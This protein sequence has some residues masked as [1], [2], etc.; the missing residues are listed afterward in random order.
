[1]TISRRHL[2]GTLGVIGAGGFGVWSWSKRSPRARPDA[3]ACPSL[4]GQ[5]IRWIVP[6]A[7]GGGYDTESRLIER[8]LEPRL[9]VQIVVDNMP[10]AGGVTGAQTI[11]SA[12]PDGRTL[13][14]IGAPGLL[15]SRL[16]GGANALDPEAFTILGR[17]SRSW[18]VWAAGRHSSLRTLDDVLSAS[19]TRPLVFALSE[20]AGVNFVSAGVTAAILGAPITMVPG[21]EGSQAAALAAVRGDVDLVSFDFEA[22]RSLIE[23]GD[24]RPLL[25]VSDRPVDIHEALSDVAVL[26]GPQGWVA[27]HSGDR[28]A[29]AQHDQAMTSA[30]IEV[31]S[32]GRIVVA[33]PKMDPAVAGCLGHALHATL[34]SAE[35]RAAT[36]RSLDVATGDEARAD[37]IAAARDLSLLRPPLQQALAALRG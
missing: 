3:G 23:G 12:S 7:A 6:H 31:V 37:V 25:Q 34:S 1:L 32:A 28:A 11:A 5:Q 14:L 19:R 35:L 22:I 8:F 20:V 4:A 16:S 21:F 27:Q 18:H 13:G 30:L 24:L 36:P 26:G 33:P 9:G 29:L 17:V 15:V 2:L 10:G